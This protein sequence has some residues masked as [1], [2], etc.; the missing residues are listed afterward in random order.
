[1][2]APHSA[3]K[4]PIPM[5]DTP[6]PQQLDAL[7]L[8]PHTASK[9]LNR[10]SRLL[11]LVLL[12]A[13]RTQSRVA[14]VTIIGGLVAL[15]G[16]LDY[17]VGVG[18]SLTL[19]YLIPITLS[20]AWLGWR[21]GCATAVACI[22]IRVAGDLANG[23]YRHPDI[24]G[25]NRVIDTFMYLV[26]VF[27]LNALI[28]LLRE[29]DERVR[30][31]TA[32]LR[33]VIAER[34]EL[35]TELF[36]I[37]RRERAAIG[38]DLHDGLGQDLTAASIAANL[39]TNNLAAGGYPAAKDARTVSDMLHMAIGTTRKIA[40]GLLLAAVEPDELLPELDELA[41]VLGKEYP[42]AF[43]FVHRGVTGDRLS[44][45][46]SS[47][48]FYIAQ[49][50]ARNAARHARATTVEISLFENEGG[51][52]LAV[53]DNGRGLPSPN[54][55]STGIGQRVMAHRTELIGGEF[56]L[57]PGSEGG[58]TVRCRVPLP[59]PEPVPEPAPAAR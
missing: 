11:E 3:K 7:D 25:W 33:Q 17:L 12:T 57:G 54:G 42:L 38:R 59:A 23:G 43:R 27:I 18:V 44:A 29:V 1:M 46:V 16:T 30:Q 8:E 41:A 50:A 35:Q 52:E 36:E 4:A 21:N 6:T 22:V 58:T 47:H 15:V 10:P 5:A 32:A 56:S 26:V 31:R 49:E 13:N 45:S 48:L 2:P 40:R 55:R 37:S 28:S 34:A 39:L 53:T 14:S 51:L 19:F 20:V 9:V 24:A